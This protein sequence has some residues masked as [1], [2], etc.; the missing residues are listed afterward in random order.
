MSTGA[1]LSLIFS[2][3]SVVLAIYAAGFDVYDKMLKSTG[4]S[5]IERV[6]TESLKFFTIFLIVLWIGFIGLSIY[7]KT[8]D[9][10]FG[11][12]VLLSTFWFHKW[13]YRNAARHLV[14]ITPYKH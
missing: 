10:I 11:S 13:L 5:I 6:A 9:L 8:L 3:I 7:I 12:L 1:A 14:Q 4:K 2:M